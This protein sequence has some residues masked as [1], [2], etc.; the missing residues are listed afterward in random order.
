[1]CRF[2]HVSRAGYYVW[3]RR[4]D[5]VSIEDLGIAFLIKRLQ[6]ENDFTL[7]AKTVSKYLKIENGL[8]VNHKHCLRIMRDYGLLSHVKRRK[9]KTA[10]HPE[11]YPKDN[12]IRGNHLCSVP[13]DKMYT[14][15][16]EFHIHGKKVYFSSIKD[17]HT[18]M[19]EAYEISYHP[20]LEFVLKTLNQVRDKAI[21][22]GTFIHSDH[23]YQYTNRLFQE[24]LV[25]F[26]FIQSMS[27]KGRPTD[28]SPIESLHSILKSEVIYNDTLH[29]KTDVELI[30]AL[31]RFVV[32]Y[33]TKR[34]QKALNYMTPFEFKEKEM[35]RIS[36]LEP[37][38]FYTVHF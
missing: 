21:R 2:C 37:D 14:D 34:R 30:E 28:N 38:L 25:E 4:C 17:M 35:K 20:T 13:F 5:Q 26:N 9:V 1:M 32:R 23:G 3:A 18:K 15:I 27:R 31:H 19:I 6:L 7:G 36:S 24:K 12:I 33:N 8:I 22:Y 11:E 29:I 16:T 10:S